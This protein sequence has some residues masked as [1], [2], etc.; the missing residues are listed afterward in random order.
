LN[1]IRIDIRDR[2][3]LYEQLVENIKEL[4]RQGVF[5][6]DDY[7]PSVRSLAG[8]LGINPN[9]IQ[10]AY[11]ELERQGITMTISGRG[12]M[13]CA[14][15]E[16]LLKESKEKLFSELKQMVMRADALSVSRSE[17]TA[18]ILAVPGGTKGGEEHDSN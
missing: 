15:G 1:P 7:L 11:S 12:S 3:P 5:R 13:I 8:E 18:Y 17:L 2:R 16:D 9:T 10:K 14:E 4:V 6:K